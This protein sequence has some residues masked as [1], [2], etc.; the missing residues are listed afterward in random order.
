MQHLVAVELFGGLLVMS[1]AMQ[2]CEV[3]LSAPYSSEVCSDC[4]LV[5]VRNHPDAVGS[6]I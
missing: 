1:L 2:M 3:H 5:A 6:K 4:L